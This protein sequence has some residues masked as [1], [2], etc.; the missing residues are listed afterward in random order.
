MEPEGKRFDGALVRPVN[1]LIQGFLL[2]KQAEGCS[3]ATLH[4]YRAGLRHLSRWMAEVGHEDP[5]GLTAADLKAFLASL[6]SLSRPLKP[7]TIYN[8]WVALKSFYRWWSEET[9]KPSPMASV[10]APKTTVP[11]IE[12]L[13]RDQVAAILRACDLTREATTTWRRSFV[14]RR[15]TALRDRAIVLVLLDTGVRAAELCDLKVGDIDLTTGRVIVR[16]GKG[17]R[18]RTVY[19][20]KAA[21]RA[22]WRYLSQ[23][24]DAAASDPLFV[25]RNDR[26]LAGSSLH[27]LIRRLG[28]RA[29]VRNLHP[30]RF[31]HSFATEFLRNGGDL[32]SLQRLL[33]HRGLEMVRRYAEITDT[34]LER[35]H[36]G[37][38]PADQWR[39]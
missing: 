12:P 39:L 6:R 33:G 3:S 8:V 37:G 4:D 17:G 18:G 9:G 32:L 26:P 7:K 27:R 2:A 16:K 30:H 34:D 24:E 38:S 14:M 21:R 10:P 20:G 31:R 15:D 5:G 23:R 1:R 11:V 13:S 36:R 25:G 28:E 19:L 29:G 22:V 35:V